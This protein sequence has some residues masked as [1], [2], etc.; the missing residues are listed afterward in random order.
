MLKN[1]FIIAWRNIVKSRF[2][3]LVNIAGLS[4]GIAFTLLIGAYVWSEFRVNSDLKNADRQY[5]IQSKWKDPNMGYPLTTLAPLAKEL[6]EQ[7]PGLVTNYYRFD[8][9][10]STVSSGDKYFREGLQVGDSTML[11]MYG[12]TLKYGDASTALK[13][14]SSVVITKAMAKKYFGREDVVG[15]PITIENFSG[16]KKD[17]MIT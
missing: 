3:S 10:T 16:S 6:H 17:F 15:Q 14:P 12:F 8:G 2:Y 1:Y 13:D 11:D 4:A 5:I 9:I 7:Y